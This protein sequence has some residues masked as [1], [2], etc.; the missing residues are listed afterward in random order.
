MT[1][2]ALPLWRRALSWLKSVVTWLRTRRSAAKVGKAIVQNQVATAALA[3]SVAAAGV[4]GVA[5]YTAHEAN[6]TAKA[7]AA[8]QRVLAARVSG[9]ESDVAFDRA[10]LADTKAAIA[11]LDKKSAAAITA[12]GAKTALS[13]QR[14]GLLASDLAKIPPSPDL[15]P[16]ASRVASLA[17]DTAA[18]AKAA[19]EALGAARGASDPKAQA[20]AN[21]AAAQA[22]QAEQDAKAAQATADAAAARALLAG[23]KGDPGDPASETYAPVVYTWPDGG[24]YGLRQIEIP[25]DGEYQVTLAADG[26]GFIGTGMQGNAVQKGT[27]KLNLSA[28]DAFVNL[29]IEGGPFTAI[30]LTIQLVRP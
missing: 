2:S 5:S 12:L 7:T 28:G 22:T 24:P 30:V 17:S 27:Q 29:D 11:T 18:A 20:A 14:I 10:E 13:A 4:G 25:A 19:R 21:A 16:L 26:E 23:P 8:A 15:A 9:I 6:V 3:A 1:E